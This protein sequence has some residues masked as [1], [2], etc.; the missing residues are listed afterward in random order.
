MGKYIVR[1]CLSESMIKIEKKE[2]AP[3]ESEGVV[4]QNY[5]EK[6]RRLERG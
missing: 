1:H 3:T 5:R 2:N 4:T 6:L